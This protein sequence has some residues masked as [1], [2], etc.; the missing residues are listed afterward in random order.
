MPA[1][2]CQGH[3]FIFESRS[4]RVEHAL[5]R[6]E[7]VGIVPKTKDIEMFSNKVPS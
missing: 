2:L 7:T 5:M 1:L 4:Y 3:C 6:E